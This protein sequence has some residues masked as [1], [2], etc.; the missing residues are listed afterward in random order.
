M[1]V[2]S[3]KKQ[4]HVKGRSR[5]LIFGIKKDRDYFIENLSMLISSGMGIIAAFDTIVLELKTKKMRALFLRVRDEIAGG[6]PLWRA[7]HSTRLFTEHTITLIRIGE[8]SGRLAENLQVIGEQHEKSRVFKSK[9]RSAMIYPM[10]VLILT[11]VI[12]INIAWFILPKL[13]LVFSQ[14]NIAL[15]AITRFLIYTGIFLNTYGS[16]VVPVGI[17]T[18]GG[19]FYFIFYFPKTR[20]VGQHILFLFSDIRRLIQEMEL[21]KFGYLT[22]SLLGAGLQINEVLSLVS[23]ETSFIKYKKMYLELKAL[24]EEGNSFKKSF[25]AIKNIRLL[26]PAPTQQMI[27]AAEQ[28]GTLA[29]AFTKMSANFETK[30][31]ATTKNLTVVVEPFLLVVVWL[32]VMSVAL[33]VIMPIYSL[34]GNFDVASH[35]TPQQ[36]SAVETKNLTVKPTRTFIST[37]SPVMAESTSTASTTPL[38]A[39]T[40]TRWNAQTSTLYTTST[41]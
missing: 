17:I 40:T 35:S 5:R 20:F 39:T 16:V 41:P 32:G 36:I 33:G 38:E 31:D 27:V 24:I 13:A 4:D 28:S 25:A 10:L 6:S 1:T 8:S 15:P 23:E 22:G 14:M 11:I 2:I 26:I 12:G 21:T 34:I 18:C 7:L 3:A 30:I 37:S 9:L 29:K 19:I